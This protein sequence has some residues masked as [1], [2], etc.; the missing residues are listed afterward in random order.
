LFEQFLNSEKYD[1]AQ[2]MFMYMM[3]SAYCEGYNTAKNETKQAIDN[4][5]KLLEEEKQKS[6]SLV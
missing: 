5:M 3:K 6:A 2:D 4:I 1:E